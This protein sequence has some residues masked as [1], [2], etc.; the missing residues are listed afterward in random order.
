MECARWVEQREPSFCCS[1]ARRRPWRG[2]GSAYLPP[3]L[4]SGLQRQ[5]YVCWRCVEP[6]ATRAGR[7]PWPGH[8][9]ALRCAEQL[10]HRR[11]SQPLR[12]QSSWKQPLCGT[13]ALPS[14]P[15]LHA[16]TGA[17]ARDRRCAGCARCIAADGRCR[18]TGHK[19]Y[20][21]LTQA[22]P[23]SLFSLSIPFS[24]ERE[25]AS[26]AAASRTSAALTLLACPSLR[27]RLSLCCPCRR[28]T[29][30]HRWSAF[31][32]RRQ[33]APRWSS[34]MPSG[35][36]G[37]AICAV[38]VTPYP[39]TPPRSSRA[40]PLP[41]LVLSFDCMHVPPCLLSPQV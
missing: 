15:L 23:L 30:L 29:P 26:D 33:R 5:V 22:P 8:R 21:A 40:Q 28:C 32:C 24:S 12:Q 27:T 1:L 36:R 10:F 38:Y 18:R 6:W 17:P 41:R 31:C 16:G 19:L 35:W 39:L 25:R 13:L 20:G 7:L 34:A 2:G 3:V 9:G 11:S 14:W 37:S 4:C